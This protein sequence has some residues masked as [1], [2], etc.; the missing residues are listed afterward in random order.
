MK[1]SKI[2]FSLLALAISFA[3]CQNVE[4][5][6]SS[7]GIPYKIFSSKKGDSVHTGSIVK[8]QVIQKVKDSVMYSSYAQKRP[9]YFMVKPSAEKPNYSNI[10]ATVEE[11]IS[12]TKEGDSIYLTQVTDSLVKQNPDQ[13]MFKKGQLLITTI[14]VEKVY[15]NEEEANADYLKQQAIGYEENKKQGLVN[16]KKDTAAQ[17]SIQRDDKVI[18]DYLKAHNIQAEKNEW[19][20]FVE[21][22]APGQGA[23]PK[24]GQYSNVNYKGMHLSGEVFDQGTMPVQ[25]GVSQVVFGFMEGVSQLSKGEKTR[26]YI[27]SVLGYGPSGNPPKIQPNENL[28]FELEVLDISDKAPAPQQLPMPQPKDNKKQK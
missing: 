27:P 7:A 16:F 10:K 4:F 21:R 12:K 24:F 20:I 3:A 19:G 14:K 13:T 2:V 22:L 9:E 25:I 8:Y 23:K 6:K 15:K 26:I 5:K 11:L 17:S 18:E 28:I 1:S